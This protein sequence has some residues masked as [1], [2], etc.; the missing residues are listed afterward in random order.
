MDIFL[1]HFSTD[2]CKECSTC[3]VDNCIMVN[4][5]FGC[6]CTLLIEFVSI[7]SSSS[8]LLLLFIVNVVIDNTGLSLSLPPVRQL[9]IT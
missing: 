3:Y 2:C 6:S 8:M 9:T 1:V 4:V 5:Q 7:K